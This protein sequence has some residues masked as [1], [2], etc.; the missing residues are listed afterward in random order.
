MTS[1][2]ID[3][4]AHRTTDLLFGSSCTFG[5]AAAISGIATGIDFLVLYVPSLP[6]NLVSTGLANTMRD[7]HQEYLIAG[8]AGSIFTF[9]STGVSIVTGYMSRSYAPPNDDEL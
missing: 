3:S 4:R 7:H 6:V 1:P 5:V 9:M 2:P 8:I